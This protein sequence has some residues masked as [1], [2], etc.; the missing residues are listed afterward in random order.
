MERKETKKYY[1]SVEGE[2][3]RLYLEWLRDTINDTIDSKYKVVF[4]YK[5]EKDPVKRAKSLIIR[6]ETYVYHFADYESDDPVHVKQFLTT[7]D[8]LKQTRSLGKQ[9]RYKFGYSNF[10]FDLW[11]VL[12]RCDCNGLATLNCTEKIR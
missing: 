7:M 3:E 2:T 9:I 4:D 5:V 6:E 11:M 1:F 12:H 10:T 8:R